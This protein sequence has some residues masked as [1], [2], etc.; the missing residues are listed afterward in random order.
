MFFGNSGDQE[1]ELAANRPWRRYGASQVSA[2]AASGA[3]RRP[4]ASKPGSAPL[5][6]LS[7]RSIS[8]WSQLIG[9]PGSQPPSRAI[10]PATASG[11][12]TTGRP[13]PV[14][15]DDPFVQLA[16]RQ[17]LRAGKLV[18]LAGMRGWIERRRGDRPAEIGG[19]DRLH[20]PRAPDHRHDREQLRHPRELVDEIVLRSEHDRRPDD[21]RAREG[22]RGPRPRLRPWIGRR[23]CRSPGR[24]RSPRHGRA[25]QR[26]LRRRLA[27]HWRR[28][29]REFRGNCP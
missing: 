19:V 23:R 20:L 22:G 24:R 1:C 29:R 11:I 15:G 3:G 26:P 28:P 2:T 17:H 14:G 25:R 27:R 4:N 9:A 10:S 16:H 13:R 6:T 5:A 21:C 12:S 8:H 7:S 18:G